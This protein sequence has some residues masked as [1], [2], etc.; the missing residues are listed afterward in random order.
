[1]QIF[2]SHSSLYKPLLRELRTYLPKHIDAWIDEDRLRIGDDLSET[3]EQ[4]VTVESDFVVLFIDQTAN[5]SQWVRRE[6]QWALAAERRLDR[7]ILLPIVMDL[8]A[9]EEFEPSELKK[10]KFLS[11]TDFTEADIRHLADALTGEL[12]AL[13]SRD[14]ERMKSEA[15]F[16]DQPGTDVVDEAD[17]FLRSI[18]DEIRVIVH[19][20]RLQNP[21]SVDDLYHGLRGLNRVADFT[22]E[23][24]LSL[25]VRLDQ[26][27][28]LA[29][30]NFDGDEIYV[31]EEHYSWKVSAFTEAK[32]RISKA[33]AKR[34]KSGDVIALD[35]GSTTEAIAKQ[36]AK[37]LRLHKL[38][39]LTIVTNSLPAATDL[40]AAATEVGLEDD[41]QVLRVFLSG[42]RIRPNTLALVGIRDD[43][44]EELAAYLEFV[45]GAT[46]S[47]VGTNGICDKGFTTSMNTEAQTKRAL[48]ASTKK[49]F[50]VTDPSKFGIEQDH[51]FSSFE[52]IEIL[53]TQEGY[54]EVVAQFEA[55][56]AAGGGTL[57]Y[58]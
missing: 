21:L 44:G 23:Q 48:L 58:V 55:K 56:V 39:E 9:W 33:A 35:A 32:T 22:A 19:P 51:V 37:G 29:G 16:E 14:L 38:T 10:R 24:F 36:L 45:G 50:V 27:H 5:K 17:R 8:T 3:L 54:E 12:F 46:V 47:F 31:E 20:H 43:A 1:M 41:S 52:G 15:S 11:C 28:L 2:L 57:T 13:Q 25:M 49:P 42:G 53:T 18:A 40:L 34:V 30:L 7:T 4:A 6:V 26:Q